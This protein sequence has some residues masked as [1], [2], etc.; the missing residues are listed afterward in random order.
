[1]NMAQLKRM[2]QHMVR[3]NNWKEVARIDKMI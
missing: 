2:K 3:R 1:M